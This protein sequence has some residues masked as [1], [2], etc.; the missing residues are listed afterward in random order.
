MNDE[1]KRNEHMW[2]TEARNY[3]LLHVLDENPDKPWLDCSIFYLPTGTLSLIEDD[4]L[5]LEIKARMFNN[6][7]RIA[8]IEEIRPLLQTCRQERNS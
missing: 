7:V 5:A 2:T 6:G 1:L 4:A 3:V 8:T